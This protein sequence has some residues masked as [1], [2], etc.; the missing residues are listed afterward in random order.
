MENAVTNADLYEVS[1][2]SGLKWH[3]Y[4]VLRPFTDCP[5]VLTENGYLSNAQELA[6]ISKDEFNQE[7]AVAMTRGIVDYFVSIQQ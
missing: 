7:C 3:N 4:Y 6:Q 2:W 5:A 1:K